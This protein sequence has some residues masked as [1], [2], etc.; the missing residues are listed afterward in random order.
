[1]IR[2][3]RRISLVVK[4]IVNWRVSDKGVD[5]LP[6]LLLPLFLCVYGKSTELFY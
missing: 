1:M 6:L 4:D 5:I 3:L 2:K